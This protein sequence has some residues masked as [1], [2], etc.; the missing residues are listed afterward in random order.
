MV[1]QVL[2]FH[3]DAGLEARVYLLLRQA[4]ELLLPRGDN[5]LEVV[6]AQLVAA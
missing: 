3:S 4:G 1:R 5:W 6:E 2:L